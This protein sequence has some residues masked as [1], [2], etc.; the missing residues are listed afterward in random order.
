MYFFFAE[1]PHVANKISKMEFKK[2]Y[3]IL[4]CDLIQIPIS[5]NVFSSLARVAICSSKTF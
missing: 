3:L 4:S 2:L 5:H 1:P